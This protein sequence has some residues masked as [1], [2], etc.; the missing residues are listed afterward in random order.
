ME[1]F[2][3]TTSELLTYWQ[4]K[5]GRV[6]QSRRVPPI[7]SRIKTAALQPGGDEVE[8]ELWLK[9]AEHRAEKLVAEQWPQIHRLAFALLE[10][11]KLTGNEI[12]EILRT[13]NV[14][15]AITDM[16]NVPASRQAIVR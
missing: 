2:R 6:A 11:G 16:E 14:N 7:Q 4:R 13:G 8:A 9:L 5:G 10:H 1:N 15:E 12:R 3:T